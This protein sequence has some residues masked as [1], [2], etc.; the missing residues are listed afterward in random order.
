[1]K[2]AEVRGKRVLSDDSISGMD[3]GG[4][5][6]MVLIVVWYVFCEFG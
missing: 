1:M 3:A 5:M 4:L 2:S 6:F